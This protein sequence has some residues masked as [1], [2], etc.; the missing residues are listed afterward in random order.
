MATLVPLPS[1]HQL[2]SPFK[3]SLTTAKLIRP[4][5]IS[6]SRQRS[7]DFVIFIT[8]IP[9]F[10]LHSVLISIPRCLMVAICQIIFPLHMMFTWK[11]YT[12]L[13]YMSMKHL[14]VARGGACTMP[15]QLV[16]TKSR[17][18]PELEYSFQ[19]TMEGNNSAKRVNE[20]L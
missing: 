13:I 14:G 10:F 17:G 11:F 1:N 16:S 20:F 3:H 19:A 5:P 12:M 8:C 4:A 2:L 6:V 18:E 9:F 15:A 7:R